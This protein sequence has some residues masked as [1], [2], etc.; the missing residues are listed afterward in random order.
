MSR[1]RLPL[2][3]ALLVVALAALPAAASALVS[4]RSPS[5]N[6]GCYLDRK[7]ARCDIRTKDWNPPKPKGCEFDFGQGL[8]IDRGQRRGR[9]VCAGDTALN[10][11]ARKLAY[12]KSI[13]R[14][15]ITC[16]SSAAGMRCVNG[17]GHGFR[18]AR[19]RYELF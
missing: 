16:R 8:S 6:I 19:Q 11:Q 13:K 4:F 18:I 1:A 14:G 15:R 5:G 12:G 3:L 10:Q 7:V 2:A 17:G 9:I